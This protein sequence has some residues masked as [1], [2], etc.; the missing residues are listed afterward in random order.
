MMRFSGRLQLREEPGPGLAVVLELDDRQLTVT[1]DSEILGTWNLAEVIAEPL[2][3]DRFA[4]HVNE[5]NL[6]FVAAE[7]DQFATEGLAAISQARAR[8]GMLDRW[9]SWLDSWV[10]PSAPMEEPLV[11]APRIPD[12]PGPHPGTPAFVMPQITRQ[13]SP[14]LGGCLA[15]R[16]DGRPCR[17][18]AVGVSGY[19]FAHDPGRAP[20]HLEACRRGGRARSARSK[21]PSDG[22]LATLYRQ[23][24]LAIEEVRAG[25]LDPRR[26]LA[27]AS[28]VRA[29]C[30]TL[31]LGEQ[32][33]RFEGLADQLGNGRRRGEA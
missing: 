9:R 20:Q 29:M 17:S 32:R 25:T 10:P 13:E 8:P 4:L 16:R 22:E 21:P 18:P 5:E 7:A 2:T 23:L 15:S 6:V 1:D 30:A 31:Q 26:A 11:D 19:C 27:L 14:R 12:Q 3:R 24:A 28:L 33:S